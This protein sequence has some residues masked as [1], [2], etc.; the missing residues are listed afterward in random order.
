[1]RWKT[2][3]NP[4]ATNAIM[5]PSSAVRAKTPPLTVADVGKLNNGENPSTEAKVTYDTTPRGDWKEWV[6]L[7]GRGLR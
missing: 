3:V 4:T 1:M 6:T 7:C 5:R 2:Q